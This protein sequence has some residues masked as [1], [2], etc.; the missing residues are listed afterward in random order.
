[1]SHQTLEGAATVRLRSFLA[2]RLAA[3]EIKIEQL[4]PDASTREYFRVN[5][6]QTSAIACVYGESFLDKEHSYIDVTNLFLITAGK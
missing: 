5:W 1:M 3:S 6:H 2:Q 4:T